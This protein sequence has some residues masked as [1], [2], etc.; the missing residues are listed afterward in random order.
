[1][2]KFIAKDLNDLAKFFRKE[3]IEADAKITGLARCKSDKKYYEGQR[4]VYHFL[5]GMIERGELVMGE[6]N[7]QGSTN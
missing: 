5:A 3:A 2:T 7:A 1:M 6:P 4:S